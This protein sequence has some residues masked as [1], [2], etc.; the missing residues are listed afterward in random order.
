MALA[1]AQP[2]KSRGLSEAIAMLKTRHGV[3]A[4]LAT[5]WST[6]RV[7]AGT[8]GWKGDLNSRADDVTRSNGLFTSTVV[9]S[10]RPPVV[11]GANQ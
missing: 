6:F 9:I 1:K 8:T 2:P 11:D 10:A 7:W 5:S 4:I 3:L